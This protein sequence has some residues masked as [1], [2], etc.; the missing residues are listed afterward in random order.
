MTFTSPAALEP[1]AAAL[2]RLSALWAE[3]GTDAGAGPG[4]G[5]GT[6]AEALVALGELRAA[7]DAF[8]VHVAGALQAS[9]G[10]DNPALLA[11]HRHMS[12]FLAELWKISYPAARQ[13]C[14]V[15]AALT[16][17][18]SL[19]GEE[20]PARYPVLAEALSAGDGS[21]G[22]GSVSVDQIAV[23]VRE[24]DKA[25]AACSHDDMRAA[26]RL[27]VNYASGLTVEQT[28]KLAAQIRDWLDQDGIEPREAIQRRGRSLTIRTT[29]DGM[30]RIDWLLDAESAGYVLS[31]IT[32]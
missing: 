15:G 29:R 12:S 11:G 10:S 22:A 2:T 26:E 20:L 13:F 6:G 21:S 1:V 18:R 32:P 7:V 5:A 27:I 8:T 4:A 28:R 16:P 17:G 3:S 23:T 25:S 24:L 31:G 30:T 19:V 9:P 14:A